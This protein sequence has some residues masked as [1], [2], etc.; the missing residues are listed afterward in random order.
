VC[1][2]KSDFVWLGDVPTSVIECLPTM[3]AV[4]GL[5]PSTTKKSKDKIRFIEV[6]LYYKKKIILFRFH[7]FD[8]G[9]AIV[10]MKI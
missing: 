6:C 1:V 10:T 8:K 5:I 4:M 9:V 7:E 3:H 2:F